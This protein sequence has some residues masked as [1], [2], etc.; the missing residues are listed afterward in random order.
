MRNKHSLFAHVKPRR[1]GVLDKAGKVISLQMNGVTTVDGVDIGVT[2]VLP[3]LF[4]ASIDCSTQDCQDIPHRGDFP[5]E[6]SAFSTHNT[7]SGPFF[8]AELPRSLSHRREPREWEHP[9]PPNSWGK[10]LPEN[11]GRKGRKK[12]AERMEK[13]AQEQ[14]ANDDQDDWFGNPRASRSRGPR[15]ENE[16]RPP[17][18]PSTKMSFGKSVQQAG[19]QFQT[20]SLADRLGESPHQND[21]R[22]PPKSRPPNSRPNYDHNRK[23]HSRRDDDPRRDYRRRD[24]AGPRY[25]GGYIR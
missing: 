8:D 22:R 7:L 5:S 23:H 11:V 20:P 1:I 17:T 16:K 4:I 24:E 6:P 10:D 21:H 3:Y 12:D 2:S 9:G 25:K 15:Q 18:G 19:R 14:E 13:R